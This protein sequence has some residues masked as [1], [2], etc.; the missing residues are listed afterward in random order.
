MNLYSGPNLGTA[1]VSEIAPW[2]FIPDPATLERLRTEPKLIRRR[3]TL[4]KKL[5][6]NVYS[7]CVGRCPGLTISADNPPASIR[8]FAADYDARQT[9]ESVLAQLEQKVQQ[10]RP[11]WLEVSLG[12]KCRLVWLFEE[13]LLC[14][15]TPHADALLRAFSAI[16]GAPNLL[17][18]FDHCSL[19]P[20]QRWTNGGEWYRLQDVPEVVPV[21]VT[22]GVAVQVGTKT[23]SAE[24]GEISLEVIGAEVEKRWPGRWAGTFTLNATGVRFWDDTADNSTG[25]QVKPDG[26][27]CF[28]GLAPFKR[29]IDLFGAEWVREQTVKRQAEVAEGVY[30]DGR[31]WWV[32]HGARWDR[33]S[34]PAIQLLLRTRGVLGQKRKGEM[35]SD[36]DRLL[37]FL[38][39]ERRVDGVG[40]M[41]NYPPGVRIVDGQRVLNT[42]HIDFLQAA[43]GTATKE[44]FPWIYEFL[45]GLFV[46]SEAGDPLTHFLAWLQRAYRAALDR[47]PRMGQ[48]IFLCGPPH[49]GKTLL[50]NHI[51]AGLLGN[52]RANP[53]P[54]MVGDSDFNSEL[55]GSYV[56]AVHDE[57]APKNEASRMKFLQKIKSAVV[58]KSFTYHPKF[59]N[60]TTLDWV[61]RFCMTLNNDAG[62]SSVLPE[63]IDSTRDKLMFFATQV[64]FTTWPENK[65]VE[66]RISTELPFFARW[67]LDWE[68]PAEVIEESRTVV[69]SYFDPKMLAT[70]QQQQPAYELEELL[71]AWIETSNIADNDDSWQGTTTQLWQALSGVDPLVPLIAKWTHS[72]LARSLTALARQDRSGVT[73]E[74]ESLGKIFRVHYAAILLKCA[75]KAD[76]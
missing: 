56:W 17:P 30:Y 46:P 9:I 62:S 64:V 60:K 16:V 57:E 15:D 19:K 72:R 44:Q 65:V 22:R 3:S 2:D 29:W 18:E 39:T 55:F 6:W 20:V 36:M 34:D 1:E 23:G 70:S 10:F 37:L 66:G 14:C 48:A 41:I 58:N 63:V 54:W 53:Y 31:D 47:E 49:N 51:V 25:C 11:Q 38:M 13:E 8:G 45:T 71:Q 61:G 24:K 12:R 28:T 67:L 73:L 26:M 52:R 32:S 59:C 43:S 40:P 74:P 76:K 7:V 75:R 33:F 21:E 4:D 42:S 69:K 27:L 68:T 50:I 35:A 5:D